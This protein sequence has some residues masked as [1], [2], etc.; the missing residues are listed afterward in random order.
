MIT[1]SRVARRPMRRCSAPPSSSG[2]TCRPA[3]SPRAPPRC[4]SGGSPG[5]FFCGERIRVTEDV[6]EIRS[7]VDR[8]AA[9]HN[10]ADAA[11]H[12]I[13]DPTLRTKLIEPLEGIIEGLDPREGYFEALAAGEVCRGAGQAVLPLPVESMLM[14]R[15][16]GRPLVQLSPRGRFEHGDLF[17]A[18]DA[19]DLDG[20][21]QHVEPVA[22][23]VNSKVGPFVNLE[24]ALPVSD[25]EPLTPTEQ[26]LLKLLP[27]W[28]LLGAAEKAL[29]LAAVYATERVQF[30]SPISK[31][32]GVAFPLADAAAE[33]EAL[34]ELALHAT[35][36]VHATPEAALVDTM[37]LRW[38]A[39]DI[40]RKV[41]RI[42]H[43]VLGAVGM[44]DE[45]DL[46]IIN[47]RCR[48]G[49][50]CR[51][52]SRRQPPRWPPPSTSTGSTASSPRSSPARSDLARRGGRARARR[53]SG[54]QRRSRS[55]QA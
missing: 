29:D 39:L 42:A 38:A 17:E 31:Y 10:G 25:E 11:R 5:S 33:L 21:V 32:Q 40:V 47:S 4:S 36:S 44:C 41:M 48:P 26:A 13:I 1:S 55:G 19:A 45:H 15:A 16:S 54:A 3:R 43:Q 34:Y 23:T 8:L 24:P 28:Y 53:F 14:R 37:A 49:S 18:W 51:S 35:H 30:G 12:A 9:A 22:G 27:S 7:S 20:T 50:G 6:E 52:T 2:G 46:T